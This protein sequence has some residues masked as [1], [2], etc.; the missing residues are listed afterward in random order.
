M[1]DSDVAPTTTLEPRLPVET[2]IVE[3]PA[4]LDEDLR[5]TADRPVKLRR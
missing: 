3:D 5:T 1:D 2:E 4:P